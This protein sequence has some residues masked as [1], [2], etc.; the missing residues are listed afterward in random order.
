MKAMTALKINKK[1]NIL[2]TTTE[3]Y[4]EKNISKKRVRCNPA[5]LL[6]HYFFTF[7]AF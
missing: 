6:L 5:C 2:K 7:R 3:L 1:C 4:N